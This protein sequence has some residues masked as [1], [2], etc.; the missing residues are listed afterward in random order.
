LAS[1][2]VHILA[3]TPHPD[4]LFMR[5]VGR[6]LTADDGVLVGHRVLICDHDRKWTRFG[7]GAREHIGNSGGPDA[8]PGP[9]R[10]RLHRTIGA[11]DPPAAAVAD[12]AHVLGE[13]HWTG[14]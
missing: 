7:S 5:H 14:H 13:S 8:V 6:S 1:R 11:L 12:M 2:R 10:E 3:S 4:D 9:Q